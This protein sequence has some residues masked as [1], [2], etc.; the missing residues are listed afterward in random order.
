MTAAAFQLK[1]EATLP[2]RR[3]G[4][5]VSRS[6]SVS[7]ASGFSRKDACGDP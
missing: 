3:D 7:V 4:V 6:L 2:M 5:S 1:L